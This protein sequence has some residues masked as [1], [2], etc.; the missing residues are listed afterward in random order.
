MENVCIAIDI[1]GTN[2]RLC[3]V[4]GAGR[5]L[6]R[7]RQPTDI[8]RGRD[9]FLGRLCS[10]IARLKRKGAAEGGRVVGIGV[11]VPGLIS[12]EGLVYSS[13]NLR[14]LE[15]LNLRQQIS[16]TME[17][18]SF[19]VNDANAWAWGE[20][21]FGAGKGMA[22][23]LML[24]L[25]TGVGS[26]LVLNDRLWTGIDGV[27]GEFG[28]ATVEPAGRPCRC[29]N[30][31]CLEQYA[32]A[33]AIVS[34]TLE[35]LH[36]GGDSCLSATS[37]MEITSAMIADA[38]A[39]GDALARSMFDEAGRYLGIAAAAAAN[40]LNLEGIILGGGVAASFGLLVE[41]MRR[42]VVAR[43]FPI[44]ARRL[45]IIRSEL[46]DDAGILGAA[47]MAMAGN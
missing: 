46:G 33:N 40:M 24:T 4:D 34:A 12:N 28:H 18:P 20:K 27:A 39:K 21:C 17:L 23:F 13:V 6:F 43:A 45:R 16:E 3:L 44:P 9:D 41:A 2:L 14:P 15:G 42:E 47:A 29:G 35:A 1:G 32:S 37:P 26:G 25:G 22:S 10:G 36:K 19:I 31:G 38:A 7:E 5:V 30:H 8:D 11:G